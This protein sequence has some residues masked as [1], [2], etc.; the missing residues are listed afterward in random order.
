MVSLFLISVSPV[1]IISIL[2]LKVLSYGQGCFCR[3]TNDQRNNFRRKSIEIHSA[4]YTDCQKNGCALCQI[5]LTQLLPY[6]LSKL[7]LNEFQP[8]ALFGMVVTD[9]RIVQTVEKQLLNFNLYH[10]NKLLLPLLIIQLVKYKFL[11]Y[12]F[13]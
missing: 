4:K 8:I 11:K 2:I 6:T 10:F 7:I 3:K 13:K 9:F 1:S 12:I 5:I